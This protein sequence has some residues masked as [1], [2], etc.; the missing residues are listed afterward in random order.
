MQCWEAMCCTYRKTK[1]ARIR[2]DKGLERSWAESLP[3][4]TFVSYFHVFICHSTYFRST[5]QN[6]AVLLILTHF[7]SCW[8]SF[9]W[10]IKL[11]NCSCHFC[12]S[13]TRTMLQW[14][15]KF[16]NIYIWWHTTS[17]PYHLTETSSMQS[18]CCDPHQIYID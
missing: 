8:G 13:C 17:W 6:L 4:N 16:T 18:K 14:R 10:L 15:L 11:N 2:W 5:A 9:L 1:P 12:W 3:Y 7:F